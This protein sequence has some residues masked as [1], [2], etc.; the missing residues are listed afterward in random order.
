MYPDNSLKSALGLYDGNVYETLYDW[1]K[2][3]NVMNKSETI[4]GHH[5][6]LGTIKDVKRPAPKL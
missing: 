6:I 3:K 2:N 1:A 4:E 5:E